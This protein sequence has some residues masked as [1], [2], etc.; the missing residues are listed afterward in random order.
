MRGDPQ[1]SRDFFSRDFNSVGGKN[2]EIY[3]S[4]EM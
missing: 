2:L 4:Q 3:V 1:K